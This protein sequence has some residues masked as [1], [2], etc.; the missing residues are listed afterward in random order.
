MS[1]APQQL[2]FLPGASGN[3]QF[4][5]PLATQLRHPAR[6][7][8]LG[9]PGFGD[10]PA[11][12]DV[13][14]MDDLVDLV[15]QRIDQ[16][17]ALVAQ[18]MGGIIAVR[19]ALERPE[20]VTH[21]VLSVTS[22]GVDMS[23]LDAADWRNDYR[24][25]YPQLPRWFVDD[26]SDLGPRLGELCMPVLLLWG[27]RDPISPVAVGQ[28]LARLLPQALLRIVPE[29]EHDLGL[30]HATEVAQWLDQ[31]LGNHRTEGAT[32]SA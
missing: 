22:G 10:T 16:P 8:H 5:Q 3:R 20:R 26:H 6:Q 23:D 30:T 11:Q 29:A 18:S 15:L 32:A 4:W 2:L 27:D 13:Q 19:A 14:G 25:A 17:T 24:T 21:L 28:R 9:W 12:P 31:F 7:V 1:Q